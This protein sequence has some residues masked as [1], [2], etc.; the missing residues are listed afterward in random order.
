VTSVAA[1]L[2]AALA[3][4]TRRRE[5]A[6]VAGVCSGLA[7]TARV[8][9]TIVRLVFALLSFAGGAGVLA[10]A[11]AWIALPEE[12]DPPRGRPARLAAAIMLGVAVVLGLRAVGVGDSAVWAAAIVAGGLFLLLRAPRARPRQT[13]GLWLAAVVVVVFLGVLL[14]FDTADETR[15]GSLVAPAGLLVVLFLV[16]GPWV[17]RLARERDAERLERI[18]A[19]ERADMAARVHD[20][21][22]QTLALVQREADDP[23]RVAALARR[24]ERELRAWL[25]GERREAGE[26]LRGELEEQLADVEELHGVRVEIVQTGDRPLDERL[27]ALVLAA[28]E[29]VANAAVHAG[30]DEVSVFVEAADDEVSVRLQRHGGSAVVRS[31]PGEGTEVELR[32]PTLA[33]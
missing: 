26:T 28:R 5:G 25:Y 8:D 19:Q 12:G 32:L 14:F 17:W 31:T 20:S 3:R 29:A 23:R 22:L 27:R 24:Q 10:Y 1:K 2:P 4:L 30:V 11:A 7:R 9:P 13:R 16:V 21:V 6:L 18:R 33:A 15:N